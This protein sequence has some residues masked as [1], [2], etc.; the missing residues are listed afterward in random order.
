MSRQ[1]WREVFREAA[2]GLEFAS[3]ELD[4]TAS[5]AIRSDRPGV[6][7]IHLA[8][9][10]RGDVVHL[11]AEIGYVPEDDKDLY[12]EFLQDNLFGE[13]TRGAVFAVVRT[14][15]KVALQRALPVRDIEDGKAFAAVLV[16]FTEVACEACRRL[17][18]S[19]L[20][21]ESSDGAEAS[22]AAGDDAFLRI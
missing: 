12:R 9:D 8:Y 10:E 15:G 20:P 21:S 14:T 2:N 5:C 13:K 16:D 6:P 4:E 7:E 18:R 17:F 22:G 19:V 3:V 1:K 11:F